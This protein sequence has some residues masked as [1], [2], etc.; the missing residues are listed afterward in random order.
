MEVP[1]VLSIVRMPVMG[2][3]FMDVVGKKLMLQPAIDAVSQVDT[4]PDLLERYKQILSYQG[5]LTATTGMFRTFDFNRTTQS[6]KS[7]PAATDLNSITD[8]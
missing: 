4:V 2:D 1:L 8:H 5:Y 3:W 6:Y 7:L